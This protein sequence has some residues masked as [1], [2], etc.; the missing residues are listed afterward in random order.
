MSDEKKRKRYDALR[1]GMPDP[2][3][4]AGFKNPFT[5]GGQSNTQYDKGFDTNKAKKDF[6]DFFKKQADF[7]R[8]SAEEF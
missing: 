4:P 5:S 3:G 6:E 1:K 8:K 2:E 7:M